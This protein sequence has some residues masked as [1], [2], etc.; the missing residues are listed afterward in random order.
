[1]TGIWPSGDIDHMDG[2]GLNNQWA[3]LRDVTR[4]VNCQNRRKASVRNKSTGHLGVT[5]DRGKFIP[6]IFV[7]GRNK[8]L[9]RFKTLSEATAVYLA[10]KR[11]LH[12]GCTI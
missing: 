8:R 2:N 11:S 12:E 5:L 4:A 7:G 3:N 9:G 1:M 10:A 6:C